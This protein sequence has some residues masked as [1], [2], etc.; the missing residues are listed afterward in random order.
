MKL[1][2][3]K[4]F[5]FFRSYFDVYNELTDKD[6]VMFIDAL[7]NRQFLG[8]KPENLTGMAKF[9]YISQVNSIDSQVKGFED[10]TGIILTPTEPPTDG[11][12]IP[13]RQQVEGKGKGK[14][15]VNNTVHDFEL[16]WNSYGKKVSKPK[17]EKAWSKLDQSTREL[18]LSKLGNYIKSTPDVTYRKNPLT[19]L[20]NRSWE[21]DIIFKTGFKINA[22]PY[23]IQ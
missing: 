21:D 2:K 6:K 1:T 16:F 18:V 19:Y 5:N 9:A 10:K 17:C 14:V 13:P 3:R 12:N 8:I 22:N 15:E 4:G 7:L 23:K 11:G 20:N